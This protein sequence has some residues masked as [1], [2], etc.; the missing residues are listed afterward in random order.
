MLFDDDDKKDK[1]KNK[2]QERKV[3][4]IWWGADRKS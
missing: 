1:D 2:E 3:W 4:I